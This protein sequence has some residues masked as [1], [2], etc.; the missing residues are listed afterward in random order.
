[1][2]AL[3]PEQIATYRERG[4]IVLPSV[5][6]SEQ[7]SR[8]RQVLA[9][10]LERAHGVSANDAVFD[11][12]DSHTPDRPRVRR[13]KTPHKVDAFFMELVRSPAILEP[14]KALLGPSVRFLNSKLNLKSAGHGSAVEWHQDWAYYPYSNDDVLAV[15]VTLDDMT[16]DNGPMLLLPGSHRGPIYDHHANGR[17]VGGFDPLKAGLDVSPAEPVILPAGSISI[18]QARLVHGSD[19]NRSGADRR[20]LLYELAAGDAWPL[21]GAYSHWSDWEEF[22]S[23]L[24]CGEP[25]NTPRMAAVPVRMPLPGALDP[26]SLYQAQ[27][28]LERRS[29]S[30]YV[31]PELETTRPS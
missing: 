4:Y 31:A 5:L 24:I 1:M 8:L 16:R 30:S 13:V 15:G 26:S 22:N 2:P 21:A 17:F 10:I 20:F 7:L 19:L 27:K 11:L 14:V 25:S 18:H 3:T 12:E 29:F 28:G 9:S 6:S 23:R